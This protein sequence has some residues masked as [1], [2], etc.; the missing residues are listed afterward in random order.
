MTPQLMLLTAAAGGWLAMPMWA[1]KAAAAGVPIP[2][3]LTDAHRAAMARLDG[4]LGPFGWSARTQIARDSA[5]NRFVDVR[6]Q[7]LATHAS[8][9]AGIGGL[10]KLP[11]LSRLEQFAILTAF[12]EGAAAGVLAGYP[13]FAGDKDEFVREFYGDSI[14]DAVADVLRGEHLDKLSPLG[15]ALRAAS[16]VRGRTVI[17]AV[18]AADWNKALVALTTEMDNAGYLIT[19]A[20][21]PEKTLAGSFAWAWD[22]AP[23][24][25]AGWGEAAAGA[26]AGLAGDALGSIAGA[27]VGSPVFWAAGLGLVAWKVLR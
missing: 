25:I 17:E 20:P 27:I 26:V 1:P 9:T 22:T 10:T 13:L 16:L 19:G 23:E 21:P 7:L 2:I 6:D 15:A 4:E 12:M 18:P 24:R 5:F 8:E 3:H 11:V 14:G